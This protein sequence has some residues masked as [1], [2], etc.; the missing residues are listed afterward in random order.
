MD[1]HV[2]TR[3]VIPGPD[4]LRKEMLRVVAKTMSRVPAEAPEVAEPDRIPLEDFK[5]FRHSIAWEFNRLYWRRLNDW[6]QATGKGYEQALPGRRIGRAPAGGDRGCRSRISGSCCKKWKQEPTAAGDFHSGD[7]RGH[8]DALRPVAGRL[9]DLDQSPGTNFYPRLRILLGDYR[10]ATLDMSRPAVKEHVDLCSFLVL[11]ASNPLKTLSFL[12]H[13]I[14]HVH[15]TN[16]YDNLPD[17]EV[18][19]PR[20]PPVF[21]AGPGVHPHGGGRADRGEVRL[22]AGQVRPT[23]DRLLEGGSDDS[24]HPRSRH[25]FLAGSVEGDAPGRAAG[26]SWRICRTSPFPAGL[27]AAKLEDMLQDAPSDIRFHLSSGRAREL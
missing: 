3:Q 10:L 24:G 17:E 8:R 25:E 23:I 6:E 11:D 5:T 22:A 12:R 21:R 14:L 18:S 26:A 1:I 9:R 20:R 13:K 4:C 2:D 27:D 16:M 15:S 19:A 7:R